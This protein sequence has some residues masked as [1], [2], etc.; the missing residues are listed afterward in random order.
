MHNGAAFTETDIEGLSDVGNGS[1]TTNAKKV[2]YKGIGFKSV[3]MK[4]TQVL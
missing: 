1:K 2:G 3:F 4:S